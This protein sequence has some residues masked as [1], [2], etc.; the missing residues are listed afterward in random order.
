[1]DRQVICII[2]YNKPSPKFIDTINKKGRLL[3]KR[4]KKGEFH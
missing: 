2:L 4:N 3:K 1:M